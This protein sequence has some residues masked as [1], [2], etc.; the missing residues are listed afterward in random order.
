[1]KEVPTRCRLF[2]SIA[3]STAIAL[4]PAALSAQ[5]VFL[6]EDLDATP[7]ATATVTS[8]GNEFVAFQGALYF[9]GCDAAAGCELWK[10]DGTPGGTV[11]VADLNPGTASSNPAGFTV[12]GSTLF[13]AATSAAA[14]QELWKSDG[15]GPGTVLVEDIRPGTSSSP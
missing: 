10:T 7:P 8:L 3:L 11:A 9:R 12:V 14:G 4:A 15:T 13:F 2:A 5:E 1:M 6:V